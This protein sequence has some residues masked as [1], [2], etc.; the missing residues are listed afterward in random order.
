VQK[1]LPGE[2][3]ELDRGQSEIY[4]RAEHDPKDSAWQAELVARCRAGDEHAFAL[5]TDQYG[6]L[7]LRTA[8]LLV[9]DEEAA[10]DIVQ[11]TFILAWKNLQGLREPTFLRAWLLKITVNQSMSFKRQLARQAALLREQLL[12]HSLENTMREADIQRGRLEERLDM[13]EAI[14]KLPLNQRVVLVLFYYHRLTIPEIAEMLG[15]AENTLRKRLQLALDKIR[16]VVHSEL[17]DKQEVIDT[18]KDIHS[19]IRVRGEGA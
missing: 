5:L 12:Q 15:I 6:G 19:H 2:D 10:K 1:D 16:R 4:L 11:E 18:A 13:T 14:G 8:Y 9:R 3:L 17:Y 7:L